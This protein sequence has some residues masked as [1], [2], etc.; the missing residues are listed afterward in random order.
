MGKKSAKDELLA[1]RVT[2]FDESNWWQWGRA[3][4]INLHPRIYVNGRTRK[5]EPFFLHDCNAF[6]GAVLA[7]FGTFFALQGAGVIMWPAESFMLAESRWII[8]GLAIAAIG[9]G[10]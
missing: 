10:L 2:T 5:P 7:L 3:F 4:P 9:I 6:D 8:Y 1:R